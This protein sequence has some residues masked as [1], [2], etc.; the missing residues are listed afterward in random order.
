[1]LAVTLSVVGTVCLLLLSQCSAAPVNPLWDTMWAYYR[2]PNG[3]NAFVQLNIR[4]WIKHNPNMKLV[5][6][7]DTN[8]MKYVP[9]MPD[10][11]FRLPYDQCKSDVI[12][13]AV[14]YHHGGLY[15]DT[16]FLVMKS[17]EPLMAQLETNDIISYGDVGPT[18]LEVC[19]KQFSSNWHAGRKG[20]EFS[21][22]WWENTKKL[23]ARECNPGDFADR[24]EKVCC[25]EKDAPE[26]E[27]KKC[28]IPWAQLEHLKTPHLWSRKHSDDAHLIKQLSPDVKLYC[29]HGART[30]TAHRNGELYWM[31]WDPVKKETIWDTEW[32]VKRYKC[33]CTLQDRDMKCGPIQTPKAMMGPK[34][35]EN[36]FH[37][38]AYHLFSSTHH[39]VGPH[40]TTEFVLNHHWLLSEMYRRALGYTD[41][42]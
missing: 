10:E 12:R 8:V 14:I 17:L 31:P 38:P 41:N 9:D 21:A 29:L 18:S 39:A 4:S 22:V 1:M 25:H 20:N 11:F 27:R 34:T 26:K 33:N 19:Q 13:A 15:L 3:P 6:I 23:L 40:I 2:Y 35:Y 37:R 36:F 42:V 16:D 28:H 30:L 32:E 24:V 5:L 7:N